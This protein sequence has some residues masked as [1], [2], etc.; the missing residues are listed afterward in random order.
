MTDAALLVAARRAY[1]LGRLRRALSRAVAILPAAAIPV[2]QCATLGR[3]AEACV[4]AGAVVVLVAL[5]LWR[6]EGYGR[7]ARTGFVAGLAPLLVPTL[8]SSTG[9]LCSATICGVLPAAAVGGGVVAGL[10]LGGGAPRGDR[11]GLPFWFAAVAVTCTLGA[12]GCLHVGLAG[13]AGMALGVLAGG[14]PAL[15]WRAARAPH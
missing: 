14:T 11:G 1:E 6:G 10:I 8:A 7:G 15:C 13:L 4:A 2:A 5:F 3:A 12:I 9:V